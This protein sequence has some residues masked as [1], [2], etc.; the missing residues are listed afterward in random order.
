MRNIHKTYRGKDRKRALIQ[1]LLLGK[2][3]HQLLDQGSFGAF[4]ARR[5]RS[6]HGKEMRMEALEL[7]QCQQ[8]LQTD[9]KGGGGALTLLKSQRLV[10]SPQPALELL[11]LLPSLAQMVCQAVQMVQMLQ[12]NIRDR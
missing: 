2:E 3:L 11:L 8:L 7:W 6:L 12:R 1:A 5:F 9:A 4:L 10:P